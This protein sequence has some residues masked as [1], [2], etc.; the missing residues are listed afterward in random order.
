MPPD[1]ESLCLEPILR[2]IVRINFRIWHV[3]LDSGS[4]VLVRTY[5]VPQ[6]LLI[7][8]KI[9]FPM[10]EGLSKEEQKQT[11][12]SVKLS[13]VKEDGEE[14][15]GDNPLDFMYS[16]GPYELPFPLQKSGGEGEDG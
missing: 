16:D 4:A 2:V 13:Y 8:V 11:K 7:R 9:N 10:P 12:I 15:P 5:T 1:C 14:E 6:G 3:Q